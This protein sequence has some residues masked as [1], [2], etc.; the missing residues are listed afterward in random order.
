MDMDLNSLI[1]PVVDALVAALKAARGKQLKRSAAK[2]L[3][4]AVREL[5]KA[6]PNE[7]LAQAKI[8]TAKAA[9]IINE[10][11]FLAEKLLDAAQNAKPAKPGAGPRKKTSK[12]VASDA[13]RKVAVR[14]T[15]SKTTPAKVKAPAKRS[16]PRMR[17]TSKPKST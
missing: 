13:A 15:A 2:E 8:A 5:L 14:M 9:G 1:K 12:G 17:K 6:N 10:D 4:A 16:K 3:S 7:N 11:L